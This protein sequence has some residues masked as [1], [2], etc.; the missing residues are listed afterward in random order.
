MK[1]NLPFRGLPFLIRLPA[2]LLCLLGVVWV[3]AAI[4]VMLALMVVIAAIYDF[5]DTFIVVPLDYLLFTLLRLPR[6][7]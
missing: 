5:I 3:G 7:P 6:L 2:L 4:T 1:F